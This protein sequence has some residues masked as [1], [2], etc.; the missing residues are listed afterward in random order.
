MKIKEL[1]NIM[2]K[3]PEEKQDAAK[4]I[5]NELKFCI[6][7]VEDLKK[8]ITESGAIEHFINGKQDFLRESP[9]MTSY[10]KMMKTYDTLYKNLINLIPKEEILVDDSLDNWE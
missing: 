10:T 1:D 3:I 6:T 4:L 7:T 9:A 2:K 8:K 5:Y